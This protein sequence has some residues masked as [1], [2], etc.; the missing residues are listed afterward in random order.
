MERV[1]ARHVLAASRRVAQTA[2]TQ[3]ENTRSLPQTVIDTMSAKR[4]MSME[5]V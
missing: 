4:L 5:K 2:K 3:I 1:P